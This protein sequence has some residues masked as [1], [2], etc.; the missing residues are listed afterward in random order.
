M[1]AAPVPP[2]ETIAARGGA[3]GRHGSVAVLLLAAASA[4]CFTPRVV[5]GPSDQPVVAKVELEGVRAVDRD[6][7]ADRLA[8]HGPTG[9]FWWDRE[10]YRLDPDALSVD[11]KRIEAYYRERGF[12]R[13]RVRDVE[14]L[15][16]GKDE[17]RVVFH[18]EEGPRV[19]VTRVEVVGLDGAPEAL[20]KIRKLPIKAGDPFTEGAYDAARAAILATLRN[21]GWAMAEVA[22]RAQV[23]PEDGSARITYTVTPGERY[24]FGPVV[25]T[26]T[27]EVPRG[28]VRDQAEVEVQPGKTFDESKLAKAQGRV[29]D[30]GVFGG[31]KVANGTPDEEHGEV[32]VVVQV[33][34][35][36]FQTVRTG[37]GAS[38][39][40]NRYDVYG[41]VGWT[42]RNWLGDLR[43]LS[44]DLRAGY[45]WLPTI[46][47]P[48]K[49][50]PVA[51]A[52]AGFAQPGVIARVIDINAGLEV[53]R[54]IEDAYDYWAQRIR[55][56]F[57]LRLAPRWTLVPSYS[58]EIYEMSAPPP[59]PS[60]PNSGNLD[61]ESCGGSSLCVLSYLEQRI[62]W[63]GRD[64]P[65]DPH[66][67]LYLGLS[68]QEGFSFFGLG[69]RSFRVVP[70][71]RGFMDLG[72]GLV[73]GLHARLGIMMPIAESVPP[74]LMARLYAGGVASMRGYYTRR[75]SP[76]TIQNGD[77][78]PTGG[79]ALLDGSIELRFP[80]VGNLGGSVFLDAGNVTG[81]SSVPTAYQ[82]IFDLGLLQPALGLGLRYRTPIGPV[83]FEVAAR[84][85]NDYRPGVEFNHRFPTVPETDHREPI[86]ALNIALGEAL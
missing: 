59:D 60:A 8:I 61:L 30:L 68:L 45:A 2:R 54:G 6:D 4:S 36:P 33:H 27:T 7:L 21:D 24:R 51:L 67:G 44:L 62:G 28:R 25:V 9:P 12:Y 19:R 39:Q 52:T 32:P 14:V 22:Q 37:P 70:E 48:T 85:P 63:D 20:A 80:V 84:L 40:L 38:I 5:G 58:L 74:P 86:M 69:Y 16:A 15:P 83:R 76:M 78:V 57:P 42:H 72:G 11:R 29:F 82:K 81:P 34:E 46:W 65:L 53:E 75:L 13:A 79:N 55:I 73:L 26:G 31:V 64:S 71:V 18:V 3:C 56:G 17:V 1:P 50:A 41:T 10:A 43:R 49:S 66:R 77:W 47:N 23:L 35:A